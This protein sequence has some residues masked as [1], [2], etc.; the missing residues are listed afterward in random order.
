MKKEP[1]QDASATFG[2]RTEA[3]CFGYVE[4]MKELLMDIFYSPV[5]ETIV[6]QGNLP[7]WTQ[8]GKLHFVTF[9]LSDSLPR[10]R[11]EQIHRERLLWEEKHPLPYSEQDWHEYHCLFSERIET[12]LDAG[13]GE[14]L[15]S[16][17]EHA[18]IV[19]DALRH[20]ERHRYL[21]DHWVVMP[22]HVHV[23]VMPIEP[24]RLETILHS[25]KS[26]TSNAINKLRHRQGQLWQHES[27][28]HIV[29]S[30][31][32]LER[33]RKYIEENRANA[34]GQAVMSN[35]RIV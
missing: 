2:K 15:L 7:H 23:L 8:Q 17:P 18:G 14:C 29:R 26:F 21:L 19:V 9:R 1:K 28:D 35:D 4:K 30:E 33:F 32:Q 24:Y 12:W 13:C 11:I 5:Q 27:F 22:N 6:T 25:W 31:R 20:F 3:R 16:R 34:N 10:E